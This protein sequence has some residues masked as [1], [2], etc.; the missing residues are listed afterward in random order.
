MRY[1]GYIPTLTCFDVTTAATSPQQS[2]G[3]LRSMFVPDGDLLA[4]T[5]STVPVV[6]I[7]FRKTTC[8]ISEGSGSPTLLEESTSLSGLLETRPLSLSASERGSTK[9]VFHV[10]VCKA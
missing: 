6:E 8:L 7:R 10:S 1:F 2:G 4:Q 3:T 5:P 9:D